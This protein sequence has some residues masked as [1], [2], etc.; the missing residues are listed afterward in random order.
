MTLN[1][2]LYIQLYERKLARFQQFAVLY[3]EYCWA[4]VGDNGQARARASPPGA[5]A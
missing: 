3:P 4:F 1:T 5:P 2:Q